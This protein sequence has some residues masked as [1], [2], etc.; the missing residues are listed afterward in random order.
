MS[1][2]P[3]QVHDL[4]DRE[5][6]RDLS[7]GMSTHAIADHVKLQ[8]ILAREEVFVVVS[9]LAD[10]RLAFGSDLSHAGYLTPK[11]RASNRPRLRW[12]RRSG[13]VSY[14]TKEGLLSRVP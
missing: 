10:V 5:L 9:L 2:I 6:T 7:G 14:T 3:D 1:S 11:N 13:L 12:L 8:T 4:L